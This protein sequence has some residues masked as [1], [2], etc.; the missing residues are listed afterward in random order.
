M[1]NKQTVALTVEQYYKIITAIQNGFVTK[2]GRRVRPNDRI[3]T[4]LVLEANIFMRISDILQMRLSSIIR[5]GDRYRLDIIEKKTKKKRQFTI[6]AEI[7]TFIQEYAI[8][9][10]L[11]KD[12]LLF[13]ITAR[14]VQKHIQLVVDHLGIEGPIST[15]SFR[16]MGASEVYKQEKDIFII[17]ELLQ[18][19]SIQTSE[20]YI[21]IRREA[22]E[23]AI[24]NHIKLP[25]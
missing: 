3:A 1:A 21:N 9:R 24:A 6:P 22:V 14:Q 17:K 16:K 18:H 19:S 23:R 13:D 2:D 8:N 5:D 12:D 10:G 15:H 20:K 7:Y 25:K 11:K 4:I